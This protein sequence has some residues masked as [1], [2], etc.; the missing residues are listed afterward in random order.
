MAAMRFVILG[1]LLGLRL[2]CVPLPGPRERMTRCRISNAP[3]DNS[4]LNADKVNRLLG[5]TMFQA[6]SLWDEDDV[7]C[8]QA[9]RVAG[10]EPPPFRS[11]ATGFTPTE[12]SPVNILGARAPTRAS[13]T[14]TQGKPHGSLHRVS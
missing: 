5:I 2:A 13:S 12:K 4:P 8:R 10:G 11:R 6:A 14:P 1:G 9:A 3:V 7:F